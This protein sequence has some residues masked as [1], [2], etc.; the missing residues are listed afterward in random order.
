MDAYSG[1]LI[2]FLVGMVVMA[3]IILAAQSPR[4]YH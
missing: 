3:I 4:H 1:Y 2:A